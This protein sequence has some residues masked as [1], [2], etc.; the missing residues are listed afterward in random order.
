MSISQLR[1]PEQCEEFYTW[2][3]NAHAVQAW[4]LPWVKPNGHSLLNAVIL[5]SRVPP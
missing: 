5:S 3:P 1:I 2:P 4:S